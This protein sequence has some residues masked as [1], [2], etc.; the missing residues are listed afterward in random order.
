M[1]GVLAQQPGGEGGLGGLLRRGVDDGVP[2]PPLDQSG[3]V[4]GRVALAPDGFDAGEVSR[5][6]R[7]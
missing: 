2:L 3:Q 7:G 6:G 1:T 5:S 4:V